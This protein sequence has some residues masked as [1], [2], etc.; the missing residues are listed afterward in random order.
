MTAR[1]L[2]LVAGT[3]G[4]GKSLLGDGV[5][6]DRDRRLSRRSSRPARSVILVAPDLDDDRAR[7]VLRKPEGPVARFATVH[8]DVAFNPQKGT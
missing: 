4:L 6:G 3:G 7:I 2:T 8:R 5:P 1:G